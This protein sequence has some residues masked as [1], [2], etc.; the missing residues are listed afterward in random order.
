[1]PFTYAKMPNHSL[2]AILWIHPKPDACDTCFHPDASKESW[3]H[4]PWKLTAT[5]N[6][7]K[8]G[9]L[10]PKIFLRS[11]IVFQPSPFFWCTTVTIT[12]ASW[13]VSGRVFGVNLRKLVSGR[14][15]GL[16][17]LFLH[18]PWRPFGP[19]HHFLDHLHL[20]VDP[21]LFS[22]CFVFFHLNVT[23][24]L[25]KTINKGSCFWS[26]DN[27]ADKDTKDIKKCGPTHLAYASSFFRSTSAYQ[28]QRRFFRWWKGWSPC[29]HC[30]P[31]LLLLFQ[32]GQA[33]PA[34]LTATGMMFQKKSQN[35]L[36]HRLDGV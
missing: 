13:L 8:I 25:Q 30:L 10:A 29:Q 12:C 33:T 36:H 27:D 5:K 4:P 3:E 11:A 19:H 16:L 24:G 7:L 9:K 20:Q 2:S 28:N 21:N 1:M 15:F 6:P 22:S 34:G 26:A 18:I 32:L 17:V 14:V 35:K 23:Y 31:S